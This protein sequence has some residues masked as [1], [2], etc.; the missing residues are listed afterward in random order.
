MKPPR[1]RSYSNRTLLCLPK[2]ELRRLEPQLTPVKLNV[3]ETLIGA[4]DKAKHAFFVEEGICSL[5]VEMKD[6][7]TVEVGIIGKESV[8]G[9][10]AVLGADHSPNRAFIQIAG[11]GYRISLQHLRAQA[12]RSS[13]LK[14]CLQRSVQGLLAMTSQS[15]ACN[16][17]HDLPERLARWL[18]TCRDRLDY[19]RMPLTHEFLAIMLGTRR[20]TVTL[21]AGALQKA[22]LIAYSRGHV[23]IENRAGLENT[24]CECYATVRDEY[25]RL[26]LLDGKPGE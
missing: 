18:L 20:T 12:E 21:A 3:H 8:V 9:A 10:P 16:R 7:I 23:T 17:I 1:T 15:A 13:E 24:A 22:G 26:G 2:E 11:S 6:G 5:V 4:G 25:R 19:D 14:S